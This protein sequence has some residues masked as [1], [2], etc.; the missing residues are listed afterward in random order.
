MTSSWNESFIQG[1]VANPSS[2]A[3]LTPKRFV[4]GAWRL[5]AITDCP[6]YNHWPHGLDSGGNHSVPYVSAQLDALGKDG[7][8]ERYRNRRMVY[9][10]GSLDVCPVPEGKSGWCD[11]HGLETS[12]SDLL[13][14]NMRLERH[15]YYLEMLKS[16]S[17]PYTRSL[18]PGV[19]HDHSL[20]FNSP[21]G[22]DAIFGP[23]VSAADLESSDRQTSKTS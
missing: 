22:L 21:Q 20:M 12:C 7:L 1:I 11:S 8:V 13:Q 6:E 15:A 5:P 4:D 23:P 17:I 9:L 16:Q 14:G 19:P 2:Y 18:V 3:Y 10:A